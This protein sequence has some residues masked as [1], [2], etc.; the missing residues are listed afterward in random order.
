M[1]ESAATACHA[2]SMAAGSIARIGPATTR[3]RVSMQPAGTRRPAISR[4]A[5]AMDSSCMSST[6]PRHSDAPQAAG[7]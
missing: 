3:T 6:R 2:G 4:I 5:M 7:R 1:P